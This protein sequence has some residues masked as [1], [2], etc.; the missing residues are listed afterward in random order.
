M[1]SR[2]T[3]LELWEGER[4][5]GSMATGSASVPAKYSYGEAL[6]MLSS[7]P[8]NATI[9]AGK[10]LNVTSKTDD[11]DY[12]KVWNTIEVSE[13]ADITTSRYS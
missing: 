12:Q 11:H 9:K 2:C 13:N 1:H 4:Y 10:A 5:W 6:Q 8:P 7:F 3:D